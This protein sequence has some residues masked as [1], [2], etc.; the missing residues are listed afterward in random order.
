MQMAK[1]AAT[2]KNCEK[3]YPQISCA[4]VGVSFFLLNDAKI[5]HWEAA[6]VLQYLAI[7][8]FK[9]SH[10]CCSCDL[11]AL[12]KGPLASL[13]LARKISAVGG[14]VVCL[15]ACLLHGKV[16]MYS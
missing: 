4:F 12:E 14:S 5:M 7:H 6:A 3:I 9:S 11:G 15:H 8:L 2:M 16:S 10:Q 13:C 1:T